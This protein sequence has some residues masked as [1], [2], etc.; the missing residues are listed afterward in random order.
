[1]SV[2]GDRDAD[3]GLAVSA[4]A[5]CAVP[6]AFPSA[7]PDGWASDVPV[8]PGH[9]MSTAAAVS[10]AR[11]NLRLLPLCFTKE[12]FSREHPLTGSRGGSAEYRSGSWGQAGGCVIRRSTWVSAP[13]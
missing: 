9:T 3:V 7:I 4:G 12:L 8:R 13:W 2:T 10:P 6:P 5:A 11:F 1:M